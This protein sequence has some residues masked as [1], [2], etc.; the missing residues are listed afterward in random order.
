MSQV[1]SVN[2]DTKRVFLHADTVA[3]GFDVIA[4]YFEINA[5]RAANAAGEQNRKHCMSAEGN[6]AK[7]LT[8]FTPRY[9]YIEPGWRF[10]PHDTGAGNSY[11]LD[12]LC[13]IVSKDQVT[14]RDVFDRSGVACTVNIDPVY[15]KV[16]IREVVV[17]GGGAP[18]AAENADAVR[19]ELAI[20]LARLLDLAKING[21][22]PGTD[23]V[24]TASSRTAG[25]VVQAISEA[26]G[27]VTV[28]RA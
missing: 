9:G 12:L 14:D 11:N 8:T 13:E 6:I 10:V 16:E 23:A 21:L 7:T 2:Y 5:L 15:E 3:N 19:A 27:T 1:A 4:A 17:G 20:E 22:V 25:D 28:S 18:T 26:A 24:V